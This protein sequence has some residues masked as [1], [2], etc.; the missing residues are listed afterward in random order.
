MFALYPLIPWVGVMAAGYALGPVMLLEPARRRRRLV[1]LGAAVTLGFIL[2]RATNVYLDPAP[3]TPHDSIGATVL[4]FVNTEKYPPSTLYLAMTVGPALLALAALNSARGKLASFFVL[5]GRVP[6]FY[7][8]VHLLL[9]HALAVVFAAVSH[10]EVARMFGAPRSR[11]AG[12]LRVGPARRVP[13]V[14]HCGSAALSAVP[15]VC[16]SQAQARQRVAELRLILAPDGSER[17]RQPSGRRT[18]CCSRRWPGRGDGRSCWTAV[19]RTRSQRS[20]RRRISKSF[21]SRILR[22]ALLA[23]DIVEAILAAADQRV[24]LEPTGAGRL[25]AGGRSRRARL[26]HFHAERG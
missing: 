5:F 10:G 1:G 6:L 19:S 11:Q 18:A 17:R 2:L 7:Y 25:P 13:A 22:L 21:V 9:F 12:G 24:M 14:N 15:M 26:R 16:G 23:P 20:P 4:S 3:W 8:I